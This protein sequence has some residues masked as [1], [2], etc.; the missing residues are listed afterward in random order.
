[1]SHH[2][3]VDSGLVYDVCLELKTDKGKFSPAQVASLNART[4][5]RHEIS[6]VL[7]MHSNRYGVSYLVT[8]PNGGIPC[9]PEGRLPRIYAARFSS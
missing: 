9:D 7:C 4:E 8:T 5:H 1:M 6:E 2:T 3:Y